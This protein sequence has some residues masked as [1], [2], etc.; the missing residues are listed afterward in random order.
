MGAAKSTLLITHARPHHEK[1]KMA[2]Q[3]PQSGLTGAGMSCVFC[4]LA[5]PTDSADAGG[6][7]RPLRRL[8]HFH[9]ES[10]PTNDMLTDICAPAKLKAVTDLVN[11]LTQ[12]LLKSNM[13]PQ[14]EWKPFYYVSNCTRPAHNFDPSAACWHHFGRHSPSH[15]ISEPCR[16]SHLSIS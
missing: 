2:Q 5:L 14:R 16:P 4:L 3:L 8:S 13:P 12:D 7:S 6:T 15:F 10:K 9:I 11:I 1:A